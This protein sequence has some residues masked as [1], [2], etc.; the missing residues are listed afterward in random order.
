MTTSQSRFVAFGALPWMIRVEELEKVTIKLKNETQAL[1]HPTRS[2]A[3]GDDLTR[4]PF[5]TPAWP[6]P[7]L[8]PNPQVKSDKTTRRTRRWPD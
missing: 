7:G 1:V 2:E 3:H 5:K 6:A 4:T 8:I